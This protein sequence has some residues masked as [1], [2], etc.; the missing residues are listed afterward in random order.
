MKL[1]MDLPFM[2][3][4]PS[5]NL[6]RKTKYLVKETP[7]STRVDLDAELIHKNPKYSCYQP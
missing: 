7:K 2:Q 3:A 1:N 5:L 4:M 6:S